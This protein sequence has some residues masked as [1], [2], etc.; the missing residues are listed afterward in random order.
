MSEQEDMS[1]VNG[2]EL[3]GCTKFTVF[4]NEDVEKYVPRG[5]AVALVAAGTH[6]G[7]GRRI[8]GKNPY[9][10]YLVINVDEPYASEIVEILKRNGHWGEPNVPDG[11]AL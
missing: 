4:K 3:E 7:I 1:S 2:E 8:D 5:T 6:I 10:K 11:A 9:N